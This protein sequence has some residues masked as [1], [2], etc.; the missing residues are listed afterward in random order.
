MIHLTSSHAS[1]VRFLRYFPSSSSAW[2]QG[3]MTTTWH[4]NAVLPSPLVLSVF[5]YTENLVYSVRRLS[6]RA[7]W[8]CRSRVYMRVAILRETK[9]AS[10]YL[11]V[12]F[13]ES[14]ISTPISR[15]ATYNHSND[16]SGTTAREST[17]HITNGDRCLLGILK[18]R[19]QACSGVMY[20]RESY[21]LLISVLS[22][23]GS[24]GFGKNSTRHDRWLPIAWCTIRMN[25][26]LREFTIEK[27]V[28]DISHDLAYERYLL[29]ARWASWI[30][31]M[32]S[33]VT[34]SIFSVMNI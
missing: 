31:V 29:S 22:T 4:F 3:T 23:F 7:F 8:Y 14:R 30:N 27:L 20:L 2:R 25:E 21:Q 11:R 13:S 34:F 17:D 24:C 19:K 33:S 18:E 1:F 15:I 6:A 10:P 5:I 26:R 16:H 12:C 9:K 32:D 28:F